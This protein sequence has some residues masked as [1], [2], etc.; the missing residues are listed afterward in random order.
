MPGHEAAKR[1]S[2]YQTA[3]IADISLAGFGVFGDPVP[4]SDVGAIIETR[5]RNRYGEFVEASLR[6]QFIA[7]VDLLLAWS[8]VDNDGLDRM[9]QGVNPT[10]GHFIGLALKSQAVDRF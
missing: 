5:C 8:F 3:I 10:I 9:I 1:G 4:G 6:D 2:F 7:F